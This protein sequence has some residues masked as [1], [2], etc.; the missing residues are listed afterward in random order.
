MGSNG[1]R[2]AGRSVPTSQSAAASDA[3]R[4]GRSVAGGQP[5]LEGLAG[6]IEPDQV[7]ARA[8]SRPGSQTT[9]RSSGAAESRMPRDDPARPGRGRCRTAG[10]ACAR[11]CHS[12]RYG[13]KSSTRPNSSTA[14]IDEPAEE[15]HAEAEVGGG[16]GGGVA[17][18][19]QAARRGR[20]RRAQ[21]VVAMTNRRT[22]A[23]RPASTFV[24]TASGRE[25]STI[26]SA[27]SERPRDRVDRR[28]ADRRS[29]RRH[30]VGG[31]RR[32]RPDRARPSPR[33]V[34][35]IVV[36]PHCRRDIGEGPPG[37]GARQ[38]KKPRSPSWCRGPWSLRSL[39]APVRRSTRR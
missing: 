6:R 9:S 3:R 5:Q 25:A 20:D 36:V 4:V 19:Q 33:I 16:D 39:E 2:P 1:W 8:R 15:R 12:T 34:I 22:P 7:H 17:P 26:T 37:G 18:D 23:S 27:P 32:P 24:A 14:A 10:R 13:S 21:P 38:S 30:R 29:G 11:R 28:P 31:R 35:C